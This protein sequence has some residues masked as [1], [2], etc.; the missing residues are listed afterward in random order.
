VAKL[1]VWRHNIVAHTGDKTVLQK[2]QILAD[3]LISKEE[4]VAGHSGNV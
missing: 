2:N 1:I 3:N 4:V